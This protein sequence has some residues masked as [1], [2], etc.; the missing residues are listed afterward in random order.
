MVHS[1]YEA[2]PQ[3]SPV[4]EKEA[5]RIMSLEFRVAELEN[6]LLKA[7]TAVLEERIKELEA[8]LQQTK[9]SALMKASSTVLEER[10]K[11][12][13]SELQQSKD[14][15]LLKAS[16]T[17][18][19]GRIR[20][21]ET[22][23]QSKD[24]LKAST[25]VLEGHIKELE[26]ELQHSKG[27]N[28]KLRDN[29]TKLEDSISSSSPPPP[30]DTNTIIVLEDRIKELETELQQS[31]ENVLLKA[32]TTVL[33]GRIKELETE[34]Q[35]SKEINHKL[36][37][38]VTKLE[39]TISSPPPPPVTTTTT[40]S[41]GRIKEL[42]IELQQSKE[43]NQKLRDNISKLEE[44]IS[45]SP[46]SSA[47]T[48][49][50][51]FSE[52]RI[53]ELEAELQQSK[54]INQKLRDNISKLE[55]TISSSPSPVTITT[56]NLPSPPLT[57]PANDQQKATDAI[58]AKKVDNNESS[59]NGLIA[60]SSSVKK[61][62]SLSNID[63]KDGELQDDDDDG[64][65]DR[66]VKIIEKMKN[67]CIRA[68]N[69]KI[70]TS[71]RLPKNPNSMSSTTPT[72]MP[73]RPRT[74]SCTSLTSS[75][76]SRPGT[77]SLSSASTSGLGSS[78]S[79]TGIPISHP[80][81]SM[82]LTHRSATSAAAAVN[83]RPATPVS[84]IP[85]SSPTNEENTTHIP[86]PRTFSFSAISSRV[87][88]ANN[89]NNN[90]SMG[91]GI[92]GTLSRPTTPGPRSG[93]PTAW[94]GLWQDEITPWDK[95]SVSPAL[96]ELIEEKGFQIPDGKGFVPGCGLGYD[97]F[98]L[99]NE[100]RHML[101]LDLSEVAINRCKERKNELAIHSPIVDFQAGD[102]FT[103]E[104]PEGDLSKRPEWANRMAEMITPGGILIALMYPL[105]EGRKDGPPFSLSRQIYEE[106]LSKDFSLE[107]YDNCKSHPSR[108]DREMMSVWRRK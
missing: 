37:D 97:V 77:P 38:N 108:K 63:L 105:D 50:T 98:Y 19:E 1:L 60:E 85:L 102:F 47:T 90:N 104:I 52:G 7:S 73:M 18:L 93:T 44:T 59:N 53:K 15:A 92:N 36:Q 66:I 95:G 86:T 83:S 51:T 81:K 79:S 58:V 96:I 39:K 57:P 9:E 99:A 61:S 69:L 103:F 27:I 13:E 46:P 78:S 32:S 8:E 94:E 87:G 28:Q 72:K 14:S 64:T 34:L 3:S 45:S 62:S 23:L 33:E 55:E 82:S 74:P 67:D 10:I 2:P 100:R 84:S 49:T 107:Y 35:H 70:P 11:E 43:I 16:T 68:I 54:E 65:F 91:N 31:K 88:A 71:S 29:I 24:L 26:T 80:T 89:N 42:E 25:T 22:E 21:L 17:V 106:L 40:F 76:S 5:K 101:G 48:T 6:T 12:L 30:A 41:E 75:I 56:N 20:E 4:E